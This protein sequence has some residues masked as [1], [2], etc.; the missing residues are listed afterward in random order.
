MKIGYEYHTRNILL[1]NSNDQDFKSCNAYLES[2][3]P[4]SISFNSQTEP[5]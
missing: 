2:L 3:K 5:N 1:L 4:Q